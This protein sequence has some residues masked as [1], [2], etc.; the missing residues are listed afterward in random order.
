MEIKYFPVRMLYKTNKNE[1]VFYIRY[2]DKIKYQM[3]EF[4]NRFYDFRSLENNFDLFTSLFIINEEKV[5]IC[6]QK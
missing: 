2:A 1:P 5:T 3:T 4:E 6:I